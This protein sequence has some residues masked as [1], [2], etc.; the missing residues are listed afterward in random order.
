VVRA[1]GRTIV[2]RQ[3]DKARRFLTWFLGSE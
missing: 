2:Y 3:D 1:S